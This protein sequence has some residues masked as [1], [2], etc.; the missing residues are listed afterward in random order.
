MFLKR[1]QN[2]WQCLKN[3]YKMFAYNEIPKYFAD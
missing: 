1:Y 3:V 2:V